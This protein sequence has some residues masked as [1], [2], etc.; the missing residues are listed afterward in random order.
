MI[1][2][3]RTP[4]DTAELARRVRTERSARLRDRYRAAL[5]ALQGYQAPQIVQ[6]LGRSRRSVQDWVYA[7]RDQGIPGLIPRKGT[8]RPAKI[9]P[10]QVQSLRA[11][12]DAGPRAEDGVCTLRGKDIVR[13]LQQEFG[14]K[15]TLG[16][17]Y[18]VLERLGYSCLKPRPRHEK[19]DPQAAEQ[20]K[21]QAPLLSKP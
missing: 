9:T 12:L 5:L 7:Y 14:V 8:G 3:E 18:G 19:N 13:I 1:V 10:E 4:G 17:I 16:S 21:Q 2:T 15:H 20:F 6:M 11:R